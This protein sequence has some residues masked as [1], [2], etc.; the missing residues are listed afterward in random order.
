MQ[1][2]KQI[3]HYKKQKIE[4]I[5]NLKMRLSVV[6]FCTLSVSA[7]AN[8]IIY[9]DDDAVGT[10]DG[11]S[12]NNAYTFLQDALTTA[13]LPEAEKPLE[14]RVAQG[15]YKPNQ[16]LLPIKPG[17]V[18]RGGI[19]Y[20][21]KYPADLGH[22]AS[23]SLINDVTI[24]GGYAGLGKSDPNKRDIEL[25]ESILSGDLNGNDI[26][27]IDPCDLLDD[28]N[29]LNSSMHDNS[30]TVVTSS[31]N[32]ANAVIDGFTI[33]SGH[34]WGW[35]DPGPSGGGGMIIGNGNPS[36]IECTFTCNSTR[37]YG[38]GILILSSSPTLINCTF[39]R[40]YADSGAG[41]YNGRIFG[42]PF[43]PPE[44]RETGN[45]TLINCTFTNNYARW[46]G[47]GIYNY[48]GNSSL[49][50]CTFS[51]NFGSGFIGGG[52]SE[53][54]DCIFIQNTGDAGGGA[55]CGGSP[56]FTN[57]IFSNNST[58]NYGGGMNCSNGLLTDCIFSGNSA[59][60]GGGGLAGSD[61]VLNNCIFTGNKVYG[62]KL[63][64]DEGGGCRLSGDNTTLTNCSFY[65]NWAR[66]GRAIFKSSN[67][68]LRINNC[69]LWDGGDEISRSHPSTLTVTYSD[70]RG[71]ME[72]EG[73]IDADPCFADPGY[74]ADADDP[75]IFAEPNDP[76]A[77]W[78]DG[79]YHLKSQAGRWD[80]AGESWIQDDVTSPCIDA[81][82]PNSPIGHEQFPNGGIINMGAYGGTVEASKS[83]FGK[84]VCE[85][86][87]AGD[88]NGDCKVDFDDLMILMNHWLEDHTPQ[89]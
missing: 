38:G 42:G 53:F 52:N 11:S 56:T 3:Q 9:V 85:T 36:I 80:S 73:N 40:N 60:R 89:D 81:G 57:C 39:T 50:N 70:V 55:S 20:P 61:L 46:I 62:E 14:I 48:G 4:H 66:Q 6:L 41:I 19:P 17:G 43:G 35:S 16:G 34:E 29:R 65:C 37:Q 1:R 71:G 45:P 69:I 44:R 15:T 31:Y 13:R 51:R 82:D 28:E 83:Y 87:I 49:L 77:V 63:Y 7:F 78:V 47:G 10:N 88:I 25:Y 76:N 59:G 5:L 8:R 2:L 21:A 64:Q 75:N 58:K 26:E 12:W 22:M 79:D 27:I 24:E 74:W 67:S 32:D 72:G 33:T 18:G 54:V 30:V 68:V 86:I 84:P 23:L